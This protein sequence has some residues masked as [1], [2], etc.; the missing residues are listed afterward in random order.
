MFINP[1]IIVLP[2]AYFASNKGIFVLQNI[3]ISVKL[4]NKDAI[5]ITSASQN[6]GAAHVGKLSSCRF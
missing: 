2:E 1:Q 3:S 6:V 4:Y 5:T